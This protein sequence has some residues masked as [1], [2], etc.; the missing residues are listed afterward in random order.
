MCE[1]ALDEPTAVPSDRIDFDEFLL[2]WENPDF[3]LSSS[4]AVLDGDRVVAFS[5]MKVSGDRGQHGFT[6]TARDYRGRGLATV[7]K[8]HALRAAAARG[9][10]RVATSNAEENAPMRAINR[11]LGFEPVGEHVI[12]ARDL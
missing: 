1:A 11:R 9:V 2:D 5:F 3:D 7:A 12:M 8:R 4:A 6:A 10:Q